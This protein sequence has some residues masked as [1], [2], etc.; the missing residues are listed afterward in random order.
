[1]RCGFQS[2]FRRM[3]KDDEGWRGKGGGGG[4]RRKVI[5]KHGRWS[6]QNSRRE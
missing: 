6:K 2:E 5:K 1:M 3:M 4:E